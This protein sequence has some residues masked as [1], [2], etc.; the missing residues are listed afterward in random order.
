MVR[1]L[2][3]ALLPLFP[4]ETYYWEWSRRLSGGY[5]DH[6]HGIASLIRLGTTVGAAL[7]L[8]VTPLVVRAGSLVAGAVAAYA[9]IAIARRVSGDRAALRAAWIVT[10]LPLAATG[11]VLATPDAPLLA[12]TAV[13]LYCV[14]RAIESP[15]RTRESLAWWTAAGLAL[16]IAFSSKYTSILLPV[17][18]LLAIVARRD[19]RMRLTEQGP[20]VACVVATL[21]FLPVLLWNSG[22]DWVSFRFQIQHGLGTAKGSALMRELDL[23]G[24]QAGLA[25][26]ILF[27]MMAIAT[28]AGLRSRDARRG[29][30]ATVATLVIAF[31][32]YSALRKHVEANWPALVYMPAI[33]LVAGHPWGDRGTQWLKAGWRLAGVLVLVIYIHALAPV[34][35]IPPRRDP[36]AKAFG[37][38]ALADEIRATRAAVARDGVRAFVGADR[39]QDAS[40]ISFHLARAAAPSSAT[41][42]D[43][44]TSAFSVNLSGRRNHYDLWPRFPDVAR[45]GDQLI[46]ALD[47]GDDVHGTAKQLAPHFAQMVRAQ[48]VELARGRGVHGARRIY[49]LHGWRGSWPGSWR[50]GSV[51]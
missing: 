20:Y 32:G 38:Q 42:H 13:T 27:V 33:A 43:L 40:E 8:P 34:L 50:V 22:H 6:P 19:L 30:L 48:R 5:F 21:V 4:D 35:P 47:D 10:C 26:P 15:V 2:L 17:G 44:G 1:V 7:G 28:W 25:S 49:V 39:Y 37:W 29:L 12:A 41:R 24:G 36:I 11:L 3:A 31:F 9:T 23:I 18:V 46:L 16:G 45:P 14:V 51:P